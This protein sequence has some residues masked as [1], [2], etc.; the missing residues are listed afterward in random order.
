MLLPSIAT[1]KYLDHLYRKTIILT[2]IVS[3][4][5]DANRFAVVAIG[6]CADVQPASTFIHLAVTAYKEPGIKKKK[7]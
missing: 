5:R 6:M 1:I 7:S 2:V 3:N 4:E